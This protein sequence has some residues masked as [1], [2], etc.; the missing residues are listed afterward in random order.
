MADQIVEHLIDTAQL[1]PYVTVLQTGSG[2]DLQVP[3]TN[4]YSS[5]ALVAEAGAIG[6]S[7]PAFGQVTLGAFKTLS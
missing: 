3:K 7:D 5:A 1:M 2:E 6:E 4:S